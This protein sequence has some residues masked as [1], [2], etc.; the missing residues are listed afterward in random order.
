MYLARRGRVITQRFLWAHMCGSLTS[1]QQSQ[2]YTVRR[3]HREQ[4]RLPL[5]FGLQGFRVL[6]IYWLSGLPSPPMMLCPKWTS[7]PRT[8][9]PARISPTYITPLAMLRPLPK[10]STTQLHPKL[11]PSVLLQR[12]VHNRKSNKKIQ[13]TTKKALTT[14]LVN[15]PFV[16]PLS[17]HH[18]QFSTTPPPHQH[19]GT[20]RLPVLCRCLLSA[21]S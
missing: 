13:K 11:S 10:R 20:A 19:K 3:T 12:T 9:A 1:R 21:L 7:V 14:I 6:A 8:D 5:K 15:P 2:T 16:Y 4:W 17:L 18:R